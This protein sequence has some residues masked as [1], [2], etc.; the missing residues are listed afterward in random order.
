M[1]FQGQDP[2]TLAVHPAI[3][4]S[5]HY[6]TSHRQNPSAKSLAFHHL[7]NLNGI[8]TKIA[9][10]GLIHTKENDVKHFEWY[11]NEEDSQ[12]K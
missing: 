4:T 8:L 6:F 7:V 12:E 1:C 9:I 3:D 5:N 10:G 2:W 11:P